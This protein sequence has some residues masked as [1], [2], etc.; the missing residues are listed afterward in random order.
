MVNLIS[1][2]HGPKAVLGKV[3]ENIDC[4]QEMEN[5]ASHKSFPLMVS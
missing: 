1:S 2:H 3:L 4:V 5:L